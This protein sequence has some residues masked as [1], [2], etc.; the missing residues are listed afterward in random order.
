MC[1]CV[2]TH[3]TKTLLHSKRNCQQ[4]EKATYKMGENTFANHISG[5]E[6]KTKIYKELIQC[7]S[8]KNKQ[9]DFKMSRGPEWVFPEGASCR[10]HTC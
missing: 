3:H 7:N 9:F 6:L 1:A 10:E 4:F 2:Y 5:K 8:T